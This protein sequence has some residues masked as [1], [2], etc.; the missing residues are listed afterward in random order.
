M[1]I[2]FGFLTSIA[3]FCDA[4]FS[5]LA[6]ATERRHF[7]TL[8]SALKRTHE[9]KFEPK[10][11]AT[12]KKAQTVRDEVY[13]N[14]IHEELEMKQTTVAELK[15]YR[16]PPPA[17][18]DTMRAVFILLGENGKSLN[19]I[20]L[21]SVYLSNPLHLLFMTNLKKK[22]RHL[23]KSPL[24]TC[25]IFGSRRGFVSLEN[26]TLYTMPHIVNVTIKTCIISL[27]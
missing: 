20:V 5:D 15:S 17:I 18:V 11:K 23:Y 10:L 12:T 8:D 6:D 26:S 7:N 25:N 2:C 22:N 24:H 1:L 19:V 16:N 27:S 14:W 9:S 13:S 21:I 4:I 3:V